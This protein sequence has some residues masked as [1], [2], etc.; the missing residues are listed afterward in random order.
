MGWEADVMNMG[1]PLLQLLHQ[2][3]P[4]AVRLVEQYVLSVYIALLKREEKRREGKSTI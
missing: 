2:S 1:S 4:A 3:Q